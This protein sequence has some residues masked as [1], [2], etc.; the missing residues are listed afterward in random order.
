MKPETSATYASAS[1]LDA[2]NTCRQKRKLL[3]AAGATE[4]EQK[5]AER[6]GQATVLLL[7]TFPQE[8]I[9]EGPIASRKPKL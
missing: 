1:L 7:R 4:L 9:A 6:Q 5:Q 3:S 2:H 8:A